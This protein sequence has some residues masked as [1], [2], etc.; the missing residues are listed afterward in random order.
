MAEVPPRRWLTVREAAA[1]ILNV[2]PQT[3]Y[4]GLL[5]GTLPGTKIPGIG[6]RIDRLELERRMEEEI[7]ER[8]RKGG[9]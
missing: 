6:W 8:G 5:S 7:A 2:H 9:R 1:E 4:N 3:I